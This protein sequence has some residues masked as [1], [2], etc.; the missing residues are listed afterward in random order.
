VI[1]AAQ[2]SE[3]F[4]RLG[5]E[6]P[7]SDNKEP[8]AADPNDHGALGHRRVGIEGFKKES[9]R[10]LRTGAAQDLRIAFSDARGRG[11]GPRIEKSEITDGAFPN[12][13]KQER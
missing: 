7:G 8:H 6:G 5:R 10:I 1:A 13:R 9:N 3:L 2:L 4:D 12:M 11:E